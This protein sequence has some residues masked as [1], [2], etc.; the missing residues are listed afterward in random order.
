MI[1]TS[2]TG[3]SRIFGVHE[4]GQCES[5]GSTANTLQLL[6]CKLSCLFLIKPNV[7]ALLYYIFFE[8]FYICLRYPWKLIELLKY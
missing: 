6:I 5:P 8:E 7:S 3:A 1:I 4:S 2:S